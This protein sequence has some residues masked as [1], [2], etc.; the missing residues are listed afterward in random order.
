MATLTIP[1][2]WTPEQ[3]LSVYEFIEAL[4]FAIWGHYAD[5]IQALYQEYYNCEPRAPNEP[6][7]NDPDA[8]KTAGPDSPFND[9]IPF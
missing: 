2:D 3:A 4:Q 6:Y 1:D 9:K 8:P 5:D 7:A